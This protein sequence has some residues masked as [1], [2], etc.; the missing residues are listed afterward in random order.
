MLLQW[1]SNLKPHPEERSAGPRL[2]GRGV[3]LLHRR[4]L[5]LRQV[6]HL[7]QHLGGLRAGQRVA[8][9]EDEAGYA[10]DAEAAGLAVLLAD[11]RVQR[12]AL[13]EGAGLG[14]VHAGALRD[15]K[16]TRLNSSH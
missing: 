5:L 9:V 2:E 8:A 13:Q 10:V 1:K 16:S 3:P 4:R 14:G 6:Q 11:L 7:Y 15:R 12:L